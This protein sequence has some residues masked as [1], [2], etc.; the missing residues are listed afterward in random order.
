MHILCVSTRKNVL[1]QQASEKEPNVKGW[2]RVLYTVHPD[3]DQFIK[4]GGHTGAYWHPSALSCKKVFVGI[5]LFIFSRFQ[6]C[7]F[8]TACNENS[9]EYKLKQLYHV[10]SLDINTRK[11]VFHLNCLKLLIFYVLL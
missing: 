2:C 10:L 5:Y 1:M 9:Q 6:I 4:F 3:S 8:F 11:H 7:I